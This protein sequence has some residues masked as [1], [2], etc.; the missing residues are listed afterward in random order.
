[1][2][3]AAVG[4]AGPGVRWPH[5]R[6]EEEPQEGWGEL[7]DWQLC[8]SHGG[9]KANLGACG[10]RDRPWDIRILID[11]TMLLQVTTPSFELR[12]QCPGNTAQLWPGLVL[13]IDGRS[14]DIPPILRSQDQLRAHETLRG[15][16]QP[17]R[18]LE[19]QKQKHR[20]TPWHLRMP[21]IWGTLALPT[22]LAHRFP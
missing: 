5:G 4:R 13:A 7:Q 3:E 19:S 9:P 14:P 22:G 12:T 16:V 11:C 1:M 8:S 2:Q 17:W 6:E 20:D 21:W 18:S 10:P 15:G